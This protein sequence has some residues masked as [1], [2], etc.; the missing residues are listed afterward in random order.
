MHARARRDLRLN[1]PEIPLNRPLVRSSS[2][3][4]AEPPWRK[5]T[6]NVLTPLDTVI[7]NLSAAVGVAE[8][9]WPE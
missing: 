3:T 7:V 2:L 9:D 4:M 5:V 8:R 1:P 6:A